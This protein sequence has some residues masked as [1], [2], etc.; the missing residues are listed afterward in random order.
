M[1]TKSDI[2]IFFVTPLLCIPTAALG[3]ATGQ[4]CLPDTDQTGLNNSFEAAE[5]LGVLGSDQTG[6]PRI[7]TRIGE[8]GRVAD[9][10]DSVD[11]YKFRLPLNQ[12]EVTISS[13]EDPPTTSWIMI[14]DERR[15][16]LIDESQG[17]GRDNESVTLNL[18]SGVYYVAV[19]SEPDVANNRL[20]KYTLRIAP[21]IRPLPDQGSSDCRNIQSPQQLI[22]G[23]T[24]SG[25]LTTPTFKS[26]YGVY[27]TNGSQFV[28]APTG[29]PRAYD[30]ALIDRP[31]GDRIPIIQRGT[32]GVRYIALDPGLY[33]LEVSTSAFNSSPINYQFDLGVPNMGFPPATERANAPCVTMLNLGNLTRNG[34]YGNV[35]QPQAY[36]PGTPCS[37]EGVTQ[38][39]MREWIGPQRPEGWFRFDLLEARKLELVMSNL[40]NP[41]RAEIQDQQGNV[42]AA[43][44]AQGTSLS[45]QLPTQ[46]LSR[47]LAAGRYFLRA[48]YAGTRT[49]GTNIQIWMVANPP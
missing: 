41:A 26:A 1:V 20:L 39:V 35:R 29:F 3:C 38:Y 36:N 15:R 16:P 43:T 42:L 49:A 46:V 18:S 8:L 10:F 31:T 30:A 23:R 14:Y 45:D 24:I 4:S 11:F 21:S 6:Q 34:Q 5:D 7:V 40:Y 25:S 12:F 19:R 48:I 28:A 47:S 13:M 9:G 37:F 32:S 17:R 2:I 22:T 44:V 27:I 33:C